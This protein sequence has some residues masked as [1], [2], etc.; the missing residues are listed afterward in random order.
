MRKYTVTVIFIIFSVINSCDNT[1]I[2]NDLQKNNY[3]VLI[4][5]E[6]KQCVQYTFD[7]KIDNLLPRNG[8]FK[9]LKE[10]KLNY[11]PEKPINYYVYVK[12]IDLTE[13][14]INQTTF[15]YIF[16]DINAND[17]E[18]LD[19]NVIVKLESSIPSFKLDLLW[20][21]GVNSR[22]YL[23]LNVLINGVKTKNNKDIILPIIQGEYSF[24]AKMYSDNTDVKIKTKYYSSTFNEYQDKNDDYLVINTIYQYY[25]LLDPPPWDKNKDG[26]YILWEK[27]YTDSERYFYSIL[28]KN[29]EFKDNTLLIDINF[30]E[31]GIRTI[32]GSIPYDLRNSVVNIN[33]FSPGEYIIQ[34]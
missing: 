18:P 11:L 10:Y 31:E 29:Y 25:Y 19:I 34:K 17:I 9:D 27:S 2:N 20:H 28:L 32:Y 1:N 33:D 16:L 26:K 30:Q 4:E 12:S 21:G 5:N 7:N 6:S 3:T 22:D 24:P 13:V 15:K 23:F 8:D 14:K